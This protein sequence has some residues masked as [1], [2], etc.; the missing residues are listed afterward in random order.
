[1]MIRGAADADVDDGAKRSRDLEDLRAGWMVRHEGFV[2]VEKT[3]RRGSTQYRYGRHRL[4]K[5]EAE[6]ERKGGGM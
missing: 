5:E 6:E 4:H 3:R 1:M 2:S